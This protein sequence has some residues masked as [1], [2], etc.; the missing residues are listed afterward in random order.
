MAKTLR[1]IAPDW[2]AGA[3]EDYYFGAQMLAALAPK[4]DEQTEYK[5]PVAP[6]K[7]EP[8]KDENG[9]TEQKATVSNVENAQAIIRKV[10]PE[11]IITLG[12]NCL[13]SE[14]PFDYLHGKYGDELG[15]IWFDAHPDISTPEMFNHEHAMVLANLM[16]KGDPVHNKL[17]AHPFAS[18]DILYV[19]LQPLTAEEEKQMEKH[20]LSYTIQENGMLGNKEIKEWIANNNFKKLAVH[21]DLDVLAPTDYH[22]LYFNEPEVPMFDGA[23]CGRE[24]FIAVVEKLLVLQEMADIVGFTVAEYLPWDAIRLRKALNQLKIFH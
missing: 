20:G 12:G 21:W 24:K 13:V 8:L 1:L 15:I 11:R 19:G 2:Q 18:K 9:V 22:S 6:P 7:G 16:Q 23:S 17:V 4:G 5:V 10:Q 14:A 3:K